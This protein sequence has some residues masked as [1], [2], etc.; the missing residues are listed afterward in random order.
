MLTV[1]A[2][3]GLSSSSWVTNYLY[4]YANY[5]YVNGTS[6]VFNQVAYEG[7]TLNIPISSAN[8][9]I[10][11]TIYEGLANIKNINIYGLSFSLS[12]NVDA[13]TAARV[14]AFQDATN[15]AKD[16]AYAAGVTLGAP[17]TIIDEYSTSY[18][19]SPLIKVVTPPI[20]PGTISIGTISVTYNV[21]ILFGFS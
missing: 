5:T 16:Y 8:V 21:D 6:S 4:T 10:L 18:T 13:N 12:N 1:L 2:N 3:S 14:L 19:N 9:A 15:R 7:L 11:A 20:V 17:I